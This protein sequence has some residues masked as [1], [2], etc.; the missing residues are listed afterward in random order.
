MGNSVSSLTVFFEDPF[1]VGVYERQD[2][3]KYE[4]SRIVFGHEPKDNEVYEFMLRNWNKLKFSPAVEADAVSQK[5][6]SPKRMNRLINRQLS[7]NGVGTKAQ[8]ALKLQYEQ[9]KLERKASSRQKREEEKDRQF[10]LRKMK[11]K[12]K[13]KGH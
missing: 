5:S 4:A 1:W 9:S 2:G 13:H 8:Q 10:E 6:I 11:R 12:E 3:E 7:A